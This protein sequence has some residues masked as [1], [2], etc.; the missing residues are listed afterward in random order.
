MSQSYSGFL[1]AAE[2][3]RYSGIN[4]TDLPSVDKTTMIEGPGHGVHYTSGSEV[5]RFQRY[6]AEFLDDPDGVGLFS[7]VN[8][9]PAVYHSP[10]DFAV[11]VNDALLIGYRTILMAD[12][13]FFSDYVSLMKDGARS[14]VERLAGSDE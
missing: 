12:G 10:P 8:V 2:A 6:G 11:G 3:R 4:P 1:R 9:G 5:R 13:R 14:W 7:P